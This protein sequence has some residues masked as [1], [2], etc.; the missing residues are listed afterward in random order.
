[1]FHVTGVQTCALPILG[2][3]LM[4]TRITLGHE[5]SMAN[6]D[7]LVGSLVITVS[8]CALAE[9]A[10]PARFL[11]IPLGGALLVTPFIFNVSGLSMAVTLETGVALIVLSIPRGAINSQF[12]NWNRYLV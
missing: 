12:G 6:W 8:V 3:W 4:L 5:G 1:D 11:M 7:H 9:K 10:R 2:I